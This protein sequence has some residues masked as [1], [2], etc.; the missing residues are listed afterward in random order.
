VA[1][2]ARLRRRAIGF[3]FQFFHLLPTLSVAENVELPLLLDGRRMGVAPREG[4]HLL[5]A[6]MPPLHGCG[7]SQ[8][9]W[10]ECV[11]SPD[12]R[13]SGRRRVGAA[14]VSDELLKIVFSRAHACALAASSFFSGCATGD[15]A[16]SDPFQTCAT[17]AEN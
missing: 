16:D 14:N 8:D 5:S 17:N 15:P 11:Q 6:R 1:E 2:R 7:H 9:R 4:G 10:R 3:V 12:A 13:A